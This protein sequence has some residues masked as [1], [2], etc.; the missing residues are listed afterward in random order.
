MTI[1]GTYGFSSPITIL[2]ITVQSACDIYMFDVTIQYKKIQIM[3]S[4]GIGE[5]HR[6]V[7]TMPHMEDT[8]KCQI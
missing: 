5:I 3:H 6:I 2:A 8:W 4:I 1:H 7:R